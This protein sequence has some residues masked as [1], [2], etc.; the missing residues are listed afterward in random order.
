MAETSRG[1]GSTK[2]FFRQCPS[3][4]FRPL[5]SNGHYYERARA[6]VASAPEE[7][8]PLSLKRAADYRRIAALGDTWGLELDELG[9]TYRMVRWAGAPKWLAERETRFRALVALLQEHGTAFDLG[10]RFVRL[11]RRMPATGRV[12]IAKERR[13]AWK[14]AFAR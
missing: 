2:L 9:A 5:A 12:A 6:W 3:C 13:K 14:E 8:E 11:A 4:G 10:G 7:R 1:H